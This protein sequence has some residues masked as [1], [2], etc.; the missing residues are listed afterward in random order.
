MSHKKKKQAHSLALLNIASFHKYFHFCSPFKAETTRYNYY[1]TNISGYLT[2]VRT[3]TDIEITKKNPFISERFSTHCL[4]NANTDCFLFLS[5][6]GWIKY[7]LASFP[8]QGKTSY[9]LILLN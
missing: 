2:G 1:K 8:P 7:S 9:L 4:T 5:V 3:R 6:P